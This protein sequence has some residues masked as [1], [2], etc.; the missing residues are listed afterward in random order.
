M[1]IAVPRDVEPEVGNWRTLIFIASMIYRAS[2]RI[3]W[4]SVRLRQ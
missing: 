2:F 3:I 4:R 1:D